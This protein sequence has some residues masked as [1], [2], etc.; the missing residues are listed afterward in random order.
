M[1]HI[2]TVKLLVA[3]ARWGHGHNIGYPSAASFFGERSLKSPLH[4]IGHIPDD[5]AEV[6]QAVCQ[7]EWFHR[8]AL[9][10][11]YQ[12]HLTWTAIGRKFDCGWKAARSLVIQSEDL[13]EKI[14]REGG[15][16]CKREE[17]QEL[18]AKF[19]QPA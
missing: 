5:V 2:S 6:E 3:W 8:S 15:Q 18:R 9:I 17:A 13:V 10:Y 19:P 14:L 16:R 7:L 1:A 4:E 12:R 11:R